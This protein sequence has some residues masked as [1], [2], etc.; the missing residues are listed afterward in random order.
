MDPITWNPRRIAIGGVTGVGKTTMA[1]RIA[2]ILE[3]PFTELD[4]LYHGPDW[5]ARSSFESDVDAITSGSSWVTE[6]QYRVVRPMILTRADT[7]V[8]LDLPTSV[9]LARLA[10]RTLIRRVRRQEIWNGNKE[11]KLRTI[12]TDPDHIL[13]WGYRTRN[14]VRK[15]MPD[16]EANYQSLQ[17]VH[18]RSAREVEQWLEQLSA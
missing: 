7:L 8:W 15:M 17:I 1:R 9:S 16:V 12:F 18:L 10:R 3:L 6:W 13:R 2:A 11:P 5:T 14:D 4:S